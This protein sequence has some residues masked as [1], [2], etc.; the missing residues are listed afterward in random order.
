[1]SNG[2]CAVHGEVDELL[3]PISDVG[4]I[5]AVADPLEGMCGRITGG[6]KI[7][8]AAGGGGPPPILGARTT[9]SEEGLPMLFGIA[10]CGGGQPGGAING[11]G[12]A[13]V[14]V[15]VETTG[16]CQVCPPWCPIVVRSIG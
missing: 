11:N 15:C 8:G 16:P 4:I 7:P 14:E 3:G 10:A 2:I 12:E 6:F 9:A 5:I 1:M 13:G